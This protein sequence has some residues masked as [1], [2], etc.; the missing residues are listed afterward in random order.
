MIAKKMYGVFFEAPDGFTEHE[1]EI[2][3]EYFKETH[4]HQM[5]NLKSVVFK[6][7]ADGQFVDVEYRYLE[8][9][10]ERVRRITGYLSPTNRWNLAKEAEL[11]DR[12]V[13]AHV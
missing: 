7:T 9:P 8:T 11:K 1:L 12:V 13:H 6:P 5:K 2:H 10:F 4:K 3:A